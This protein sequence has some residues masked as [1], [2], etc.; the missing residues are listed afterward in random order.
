MAVLAQLH[1]LV[2]Q[3]ADL[4]G[5]LRTLALHIEDLVAIPSQ[6]NHVTFLEIDDFACNRQQRRY[7]RRDEIFFCTDTQQQRAAATRA[8]KLVRIVRRDHAD[9]VCAD[10]F[11]QRCLC[12]HQ[13]RVSTRVVAMDQV[14]DDFGIGVRAEFI[15]FGG[16]TGTQ[17]FIVFD[18]AVMHYGD[19]IFADVWMRVAFAWHAM[20]RPAGMGNADA[21]LDI[22]AFFDEVSDSP[23]AAHALQ[24]SVMHHHQS[25]RIVTAIFQTLQS[26]QQD[27]HN[28]ALRH[29]TYDSTHFLTPVKNCI[30]KQI[31]NFR[32]GPCPRLFART[33]PAPHK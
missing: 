26:F 16:K 27:R 20:G 29:G 5:T 11:G 21:A 22:C 12:C 2:A 24:Q 28:I 25:G 32:S 4:H 18:D 13:Q 17:R 15:A 8:N 31:G 1:A 9:G 3:F 6:F 10:Q 14:S 19:V 23:D 7:V 30:L 33:W